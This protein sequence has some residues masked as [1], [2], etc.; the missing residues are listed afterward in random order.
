MIPSALYA[1]T[2][3]ID[4]NV[5]AVMSV[6]PIPKKIPLSMGFFQWNIGE[7]LRNSDT[8][9]LLIAVMSVVIGGDDEATPSNWVLLDPVGA[10]AVCSLPLLPLDPL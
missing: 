2:D 4:K 7:N 8:K 6:K 1:T 10:A 5:S 9:M 3:I